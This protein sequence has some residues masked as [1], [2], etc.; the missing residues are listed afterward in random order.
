MRLSHIRLSDGMNRFPVRGVQAAAVQ[1]GRSLRGDERIVMDEMEHAKCGLCG[2][3]NPL[4]YVKVEGNAF[5]KCADCGFV[6]LYPRP[7]SRPEEVADG[8]VEYL[9]EK[10]YRK[11]YRARYYQRI[12]RELEEFRKTGRMLEVGCASGGF[13]NAARNADW[14][15]TGIEIAD[16]LARIGRERGLDIRTCDIADADLPDESFDVAVLN[17]VIEHVP[18]PRNVMA[19]LHRVLRPGG[20]AWLH[21]PNYN[22]TAILMAANQHNYPGEHLSCFTTETLPRLCM[23]EGLQPR[24]VK[25]TGF[26][27]PGR[28]KTW[29]KPIEKVLSH[30][31]SRLGKG[32]R[33]RILAVKK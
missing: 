13:L 21:T 11:G 29:C 2:A 24:Y 9:T 19:I 23:E 3:D 30:V 1:G 8:A 6:Y 26:R 32:H 7:A 10:G 20:A 4:P 17:M 15:A 18:S 22:S 27:F 16:K 28:R 33:M 14:Q 31:L 5:F 25:T 12:L